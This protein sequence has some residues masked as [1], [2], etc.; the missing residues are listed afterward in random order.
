M[1]DFS[2]TQAKG[3]AVDI[4][5]FLLTQF[6]LKTN[7]LIWIKYSNVIIWYYEVRIKEM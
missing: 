7:F 3:S 1:P 5:I 6:F 4:V 2:T